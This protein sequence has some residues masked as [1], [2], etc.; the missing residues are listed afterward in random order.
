MH[1]IDWFLPEM[2]KSAKLRCFRN[3][4]PAVQMN[5]FELEFDC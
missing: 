2:L 5:S 1:S 3:D 4:A